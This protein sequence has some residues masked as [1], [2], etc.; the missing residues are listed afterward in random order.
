MVLFHPHTVIVNLSFQHRSK[1]PL[2]HEW[3]GRLCRKTRRNIC[4]GSGTAVGPETGSVCGCCSVTM[5][6]AVC[7]SHSCLRSAVNSCIFAH[8]LICKY[9]VC[10]DLLHESWIRK[11]SLVAYTHNPPGSFL[12]KLS[13][14]S[15]K[16]WNAASQIPQRF[17]PCLFTASENFLN[18]ST[19]AVEK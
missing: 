2:S 13:P 5:L 10:A 4:R 8:S 15:G 16:F 19:R 18:D 17:S 11:C 14:E 12:L 7:G 3:R 1:F 9:N 6:A